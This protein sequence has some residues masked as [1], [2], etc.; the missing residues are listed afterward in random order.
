MTG[1]NLNQPAAEWLREQFEHEWCAECG[2]E[3][4]LSFWPGDKRLRAAFNESAGET[5][6]A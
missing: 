1:G 5:V 6:L 2:R 4:Y 3:V